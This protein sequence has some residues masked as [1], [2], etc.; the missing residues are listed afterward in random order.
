LTEA[1]HASSRE[2]G[3]AGPGPEG[4]GTSAAVRRPL[5][6]GL[7]LNGHTAAA[8]VDHVLDRI[9][10]DG[11]AQIALVIL[12]GATSSAA[13][14]DGGRWTERARTWYRNRHLLAF[15]LYQRLDERRYR[16]AL[17][18]TR[19]VD[20]TPRLA[21]A[22]TL[23]VQPRTSSFCDYFEESDLATIATYDLDVALRLGFGILKAGALQI[24][25]HGVWSYHH[26]DNAVDRGG[27]AGFWEVA[28]Q[29]EVTRAVLQR[30][31]EDPDGG[32]ILA[33]SYSST[34]R[35]SP[36]LNRA[37]CYWPAAEL[38][39]SRL[40]ELAE[41]GGPTTAAP[42]AGMPAVPG[43]AGRWSAH[44]ERLYTHPTTGDVVRHT[45]RVAARLLRS[46]LRSLIFREQWILEYHMTRARG[47]AGD[48]PDGVFHRFK[49]LAPPSDRFWADPFPVFHD[50]RHYV[51]FEEFPFAAKHGHIC[52][53]GMDAG[54][55]IGEPVIALERPY[56]LSYPAVFEWA[57]EW[58]MVPETG[59]RRAVELYR[60][61]RFPDRWEHVADLV[62]GLLA[63]DATIARIEGRWWMFAGVV[64]N[65]S[66]EATALHLFSA[67]DPLGPWTPHVRNPVKVD[68]RG[69]RPGGRVFQSGDRYY[70]VGQD[71]APSYGSGLR[72]YTIDRLDDGG[73]AETEVERIRPG[74]RKGL[75][76]THTLNAAQGLT[77]IDT[78]RVRL[79]LR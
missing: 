15:S 4:A 30:L 69:A 19:P 33:C 70:R 74:W 68:V 1:S 52:V 3:E 40:R 21:G 58:Y 16:P 67:P 49:E 29:H 53:V 62:T 57:G 37:N 12:N 44:S 26:G 77:V 54:G 27:P 48:V 31:T 20:L 75:V 41:R 2:Q 38:L 25:R 17:D 39:I 65:G 8:W 72:L 5:R 18:P 14:G 50:G 55:P 22:A 7:L 59:L 63:V 9:T 24:A 43:A 73:Y 60:A 47:P 76:G 10:A 11:T 45:A 42:D 35:F 13:A 46:K 6:V 64:V 71:G 36:T 34:N 51:F 79:R 28:E 78:R 66:S 32:E 61:V 56:H 23:T